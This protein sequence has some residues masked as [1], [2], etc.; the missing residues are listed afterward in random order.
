MKLSFTL[1]R[2]ILLF[3][4]TNLLGLPLNVRYSSQAISDS[5]ETELPYS[6]SKGHLLI[7]K[8]E[9]TK[10]MI[11]DYSLEACA[12]SLF[13]FLKL[14]QLCFFVVVF[15]ISG[16]SYFSF[17]STSLAYINIPKNKG[18]TKITWDK[19]LTTTYI[20]TWSRCRTPVH[21]SLI[22]NLARHP[23]SLFD[24]N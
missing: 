22:G 9:K 18:K 17:V 11:V 12:N 13:Q 10:A 7:F 14:M 16:N 6:N 20:N 24:G 5:S 2:F 4:Q 19:K 8:E 1:F 15:F 21:K 3:W 23:F